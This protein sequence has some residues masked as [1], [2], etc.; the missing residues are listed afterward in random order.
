M[1]ATPYLLG[2][3]LDTLATGQKRELILDLTM[4]IQ[5]LGGIH[6][7]DSNMEDGLVPDEEEEEE[8]EDEHLTKVEIHPFDLHK[9]RTLM[10]SF[11]DWLMF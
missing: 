8:E 4:M 7:K 11:E 10:T 1:C 9:M 2:L 3:E 6:H 5:L